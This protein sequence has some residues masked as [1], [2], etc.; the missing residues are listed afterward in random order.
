MGLRKTDTEFAKITGATCD[1]CDKELSKDFLGRIENHMMI[2]GYIGSRVKE[3][4]ICIPC[5][6]DKFKDI[7]FSDKPNTIGYC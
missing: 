1:C 5:I 7:K 6:E 4:L 3:A 2:K